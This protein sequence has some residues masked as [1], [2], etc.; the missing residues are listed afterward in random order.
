MVIDQIDGVNIAGFKPEV[1]RQK[2]ERDSD[3]SSVD[4]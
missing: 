2:P 1:I 4:P 3:A